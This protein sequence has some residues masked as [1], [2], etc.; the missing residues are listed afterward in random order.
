MTKQNVTT[1]IWSIVEALQ[2]SL[3]AQ[4]LDAESVD[5]AVNRK[6]AS[7]MSL[8]WSPSSGHAVAG[9]AESSDMALQLLLATPAQA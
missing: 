4:G 2:R 7:M 5:T 1:S 3:E 9:R 6:V 8:L